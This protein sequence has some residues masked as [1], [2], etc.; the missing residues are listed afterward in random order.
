MGAQALPVCQ[1]KNWEAGAKIQS[2][3]RRVKVQRSSSA[4]FFLH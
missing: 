1:L 4:R 3:C 2:P